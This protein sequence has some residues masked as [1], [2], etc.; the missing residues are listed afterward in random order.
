MEGIALHGL[1]FMTHNPTGFSSQT[2]ERTLE[3]RF[4]LFGPFDRD[5]E[6]VDHWS[7]DSSMSTRSKR[8]RP[9]PKI[10]VDQALEIFRQL[11]E[12]AQTK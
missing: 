4:K 11:A 10:P 7:Y 5:T 9:H 8:K 12:A 3:E 2:T 6:K 1:N